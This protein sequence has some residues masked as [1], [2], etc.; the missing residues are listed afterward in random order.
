MVEH[1]VTAVS[2][3]TLEWR[4]Q[5]RVDLLAEN[6][7]HLWLIP[8]EELPTTFTAGFCDGLTEREFSRAA[9]I[10][11]K[12]KRRLYSGG[13]IGLRMLLEYYSGI[14]RDELD[15]VY[16]E[17]GKPSLKDQA[18]LPRL[19]FNYTVSAG[20]ALYA[21]SW[22]RDLGIDLEIL[23]RRIETDL[24]AKRI[25]TKAELTNWHQIPDQQRNS[26]MLACWTRKEAYG[27]L[28]GVG[29]RYAMNDVDL[30]VALHSESWVSRVTGLFGE[31]DN[32]LRHVAGVQV[33][34]P[35]LGAASVMYFNEAAEQ[36]LVG[37]NVDRSAG[38]SSIFDPELLGF[39][40]S[41]GQESLK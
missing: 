18:G 5:S 31:A 10:L 2:E 17:R 28:L 32:R 14:S 21:F 11:D 7:I 6:Q 37:H 25:L 19:E 39:I 40:Y 20:F 3:R 23:P 9:K 27:K 29:I 38:S 26:A 4:R 13:R 16:G 30:F 15:F 35:V 8:L 22:G 1:R 34:L 36:N 41:R 33:G 12:G 24:L